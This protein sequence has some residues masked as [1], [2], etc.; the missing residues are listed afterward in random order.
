ML[1]GEMPGDREDQ[2]G[3]PFVGPAGRMLD[4]GLE[5]AGIDR[6]EVYVTN[7]V[8]HFKWEPRGKRRLHKRPSSA[9]A[10]ACMPWL[11]LEIELVEPRIIVCLGATAAH[12]LIGRSF[13]VLRDRGRFVSS[14][15]AARVTA[16]VHPSALLRLPH[17]ADRAAEI[18]KFEADLAKVRR[19]LEHLTSAAS[20]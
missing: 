12:A 6:S 8:K 2:A 13:S 9:E 16:T 18:E 4:A 19:E 1:V 17:G 10:A 11:E 20:S 14:A 3:K 15:H 7:V 5:A